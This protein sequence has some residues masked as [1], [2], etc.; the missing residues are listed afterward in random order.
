MIEFRC[1]G[2]QQGFIIARLETGG[3]NDRTHL[4]GGD[5]VFEFLDAIGRVDRDQDKPGTGGRE[6]GQYPFGAVWC[7]DADTIATR[8]AQRQKICGQRIGLER[9]FTPAPANILAD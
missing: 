7:P 8:Q 4:D 3:D 5:R 6:L 9:Q 1:H 2:A